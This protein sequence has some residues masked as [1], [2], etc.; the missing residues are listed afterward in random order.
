MLGGSANA[1]TGRI[2]GSV[3]FD[4]N[5]DGMRSASELPAANVT[6]VLDE[7]YS[8]RTDDQGRFVFER[9][10]VGAHTLEAIPDNLPLPWSIDEAR[11]RRNVQVDVRGETM[12]DIG[13][14]RPR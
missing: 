7:R 6:I 3:F 12:I 4:D 1:A 8:V 5:G 13:A 9:V 14:E 10:A 11:A 2:A